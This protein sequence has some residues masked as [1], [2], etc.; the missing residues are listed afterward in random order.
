MI[1]VVTGGNDGIGYATSRVLARLGW[2]VILVARDASRAADA[3]ARLAAETGNR[4]IEYV[5]ADLSRQQS[6]REAADRILGRVDRLDVLIN[7]A[8]ATFSS[9][10]LTE[11]GIERTI[12]TNH[13]GYFLL[14]GMLLDPVRRA[15]AGRIVNVAS[16]GHRRVA[17]D[18]ESFTRDNGYFVLRAYDQ[19]KLANVLFTVELAQ[20]LRGTG[21]T[22]NCLHPGRIATRIGT[23]PSMSRF[24]ALAW[25]ALAAA[26]GR[27][28][29]A[30][31]RPSVHLATAEE[32]RDVSGRYFTGFTPTLNLPV[33]RIR[34]ERMNPAADDPAV[35]AELWRI[36]EELSGFTFPT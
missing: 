15:P 35:R 23:K 7:N 33:A 25:R 3:V 8:A 11:D 27:S 6:I 36:S 34:E 30:G 28:P 18:F 13:F 9:F 1:A 16:N 26:T 5:L 4:E 12:A 10:D 22:V 29:E 14:T 32:V 2:R 20:R 21:V 31:A 19:S 24:H 17:P